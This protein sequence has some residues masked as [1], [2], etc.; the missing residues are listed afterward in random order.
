MFLLI[1]Q[2]ISGKF[3]SAARCGP[4]DHFLNMFCSDHTG[5]SKCRKIHQTVPFA[6]IIHQIFQML[7]D[8][9]FIEPPEGAPDIPIGKLPS[10]SG[11]GSG[12]S[13]PVMNHMSHNHNAAA[14]HCPDK[15]DC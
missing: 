14:L 5:V 4:V 12:T 7:R 10:G 8:Q 15:T 9:C 2:Q 1:L 6:D 13:P 11:S 3:S